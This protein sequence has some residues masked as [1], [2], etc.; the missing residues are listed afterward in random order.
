MECQM[1]GTALT[2][3]VKMGKGVKEEN[4]VVEVEAC[5]EMAPTEENLS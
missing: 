1:V 5:P 2:K 3:V 4:I